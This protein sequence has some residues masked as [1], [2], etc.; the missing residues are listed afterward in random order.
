MPIIYLKMMDGD[1]VIADATE[2][3]DGMKLKNAARLGMTHQGL[4]MMPMNPFITDKE[5][6]VPNSFIVYTGTPEDEIKNAYN[7]KFGSGLVVATN[8][9]LLHG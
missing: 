8:S 5:V 9:G 6:V 4:A 7:A 2:T 1:D 3:N